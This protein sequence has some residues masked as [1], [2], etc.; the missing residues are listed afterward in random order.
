[1]EGFFRSLQFCLKN[2]QQAI[3]YNGKFK[4]KI[5]LGVLSLKKHKI[6]MTGGGSAGHV[7]PNLALIPKLTALGYEVQY[8]GLSL[9]HI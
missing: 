5:L 8:I 1:M 7:T 6:V 2:E 4:I 3:V 9:I